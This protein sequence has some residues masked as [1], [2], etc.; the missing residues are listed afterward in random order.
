MCKRYESSTYPTCNVK[1][2][3]IWYCRL[4][5]PSIILNEVEV[6][7]GNST[8][9]RRGI[10]QCLRSVLRLMQHRQPLERPL[11][12]I[13]SQTPFPPARQQHHLK[14]HLI[15]SFFKAFYPLTGTYRPPGQSHP[16]PNLSL[17]PPDSQP[18][19]FIPR[20]QKTRPDSPAAY[21]PTTRPS[22]LPHNS[23]SQTARTPTSYQSHPRPSL[24]LTVP[25]LHSHHLPL[26]AQACL[27]RMLRRCYF[28]RIYHCHDMLCSM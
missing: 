11:H 3:L 16:P 28:C 10:E 26:R 5:H 7:R 21:S 19:I 13:P 2:R 15:S 4:E 9:M 22:P 25:S 1:V 12:A 24:P 17:L 23:H 14:R 8:S 6:D 18:L 27:F 20:R